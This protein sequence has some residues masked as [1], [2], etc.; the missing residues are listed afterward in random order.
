[1]LVR[2]VLILAI[3]TQAAVFAEGVGEWWGGAGA[4]GTWAG[5]RPAFE[6]RGINFGGRWW[7]TL[8][9]VVDGGVRRGWT[10]DQELAFL[11]DVDVARMTGWES[12]EGLKFFGEVRWRDGLNANEYA[13]ASPVFNPALYQSGMGWRLMPFGF[14]YIS[15]G[16]WGREGLVEVRGGWVNPY[17]TFIQQ[18]GSKFFRNNMI[19]SSKGLTANGVG[20]SSSYAAWGGSLKVR[21]TAETYVVGGMYMAIPNGAASSNHGLDFSG[22][23]PAGKNGLFAM[24]EAGWTPSW[25]GLPGKYAFGGYYWGLEA[26]VFDG[27]MHDGRWGLYWQADQFLWREP[28]G[29][30]SKG[31]AG[32]EQGFSVISYAAFAPPSDNAMPFYFHV[33]GIYRGL[34]PGRDADAAGVAFA[35][36]Q[37]SDDLIQSEVDQGISKVHDMEGVLEFDYRIQ[38]NHWAYVQPFLQYLIRPGGRN[39]VANATVLGLHMGVVF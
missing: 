28:A 15:P 1:M 4:T 24:G 12:L 20:W 38:L 2:F 5:W 16:W 37:Y 35:F 33:G 21:P 10:F 22:A 30:D 36:G 9:G 18:P 25:W 29:G 19:N 23:L 34:L 26:V 7:G 14:E 17:T 31:S 11:V 32:G 39:A 27:G 3:W 6:E 13:G 8:L